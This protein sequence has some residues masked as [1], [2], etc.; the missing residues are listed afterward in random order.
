MNEKT[1][2]E[3][4][5]K[6]LFWD[7]DVSAIEAEKHQKFIITKVLK[8]GLYDDWKKTKAFY[9]TDTIVRIAK[10]IQDLDSKTIAFLSLIGQL[11]KTEFLCFT[12]T[13]LM[14]K[15]WHF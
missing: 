1:Y 11:S 6:H 9:G 2:I 4:L 14:P 5:S 7:V 12:S 8:Y 3:S 15:H 13:P 10:T